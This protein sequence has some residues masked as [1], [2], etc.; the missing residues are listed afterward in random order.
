MGTILCRRLTLTQNIFSSFAV[1]SVPHLFS[2][3]RILNSE[4]KSMVSSDM[5]KWLLPNNETST[6]TRSEKKQLLLLPPQLAK[7]GVS[8][9]VWLARKQNCQETAT[10]DNN[11]WLAKK[12]EVAQ[13]EASVTDLARHVRKGLLVAGANVLQNESQKQKQETH[14][15][16]EAI[17]DLASQVRHSLLVAGGSAPVQNESQ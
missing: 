9:S 10:K 15:H 11:H 8:Y 5:Q 12:L 7:S 1:S 17:S 14:E 6:I 3:S 13:Q 4:Q 2:K 16:E